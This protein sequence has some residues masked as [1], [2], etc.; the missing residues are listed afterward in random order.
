MF[1]IL[2][3]DHCNPEALSYSYKREK[4]IEQILFF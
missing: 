1:K 3:L 4:F 2:N